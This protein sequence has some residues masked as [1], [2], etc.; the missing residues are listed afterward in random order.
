MEIRNEPKPN[1]KELEI[2]AETCFDYG[3]DLTDPPVP[4]LCGAETCRGIMVG[5]EKWKELKREEALD[6]VM[7]KQVTRDL[8]RMLQAKI[9]Q[10]PKLRRALARARKKRR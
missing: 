3:C 6:R 4:C 2:L 9:A 8:K 7:A 1:I 10:N 5:A